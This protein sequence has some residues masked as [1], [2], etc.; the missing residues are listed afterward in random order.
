MLFVSA[1][2]SIFMIAGCQGQTQQ[3]PAATSAFVSWSDDSVWLVADGFLPEELAGYRCK[4]LL[5]AEQ[6]ATQDFRLTTPSKALAVLEK[7][8]AERK[9]QFA[10]IPMTAEDCSEAKLGPGYN[11]VLEQMSLLAASLARETGDNYVIIAASAAEVPRIRKEL[12]QKGL[13]DD[14]LQLSDH[15]SDRLKA[16]STLLK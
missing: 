2:L 4:T 16:M 15:M 13:Q 6:C 5:S 7:W 8:N 1:M 9:V 10:V 14:T 3:I 12:T 11:L